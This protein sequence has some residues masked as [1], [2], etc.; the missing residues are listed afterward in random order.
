MP[1]LSLPSE[2]Q[3]QELETKLANET[4]DARYS[5]LYLKQLGIDID[6][7]G[8]LRIKNLETNEYELFVTEKDPLTGRSIV[9]GRGA[10][11]IVK[12][13]INLKTKERYILKMALFDNGD[14]A[15]NNN[16]EAH[17]RNEAKVNALFKRGDPRI[18]VKITLDKQPKAGKMY[19]IQ[20]YIPGETLSQILQSQSISGAEERFDIMQKVIAETQ[21][22]HDAGYLHRDLKVENILC[23]Q[24]TKIVKLIDLAAARCQKE[25]KSDGIQGTPGCIAPEIYQREEYSPASEMFAL[26]GILQDIFGIPEI[27]EGSH[28]GNFDQ[29]AKAELTH[30]QYEALCSLAKKMLMNDPAL[31]I[32]FPKMIKELQSI[33]SRPKVRSAVIAGDL[34]YIKQFSQTAI[35]ETLLEIEKGESALSLAVT[36]DKLDIVCYLI[37]ES[38]HGSATETRKALLKKCLL[39]KN[40]FG[41]N[42]LHQAV[43]GVEGKFSANAC[44]IVTLLA[45]TAD[46]LGISHY[47]LLCNEGASPLT[48]VQ[49]A[50]DSGNYPVLKTLVELG[51]ANQ[52]SPIEVAKTARTSAQ[53]LDCLNYLIAH[54]SL[55]K[56]YFTQQGITE[57]VPADQQNKLMEMQLLLAFEKTPEVALQA[58]KYFMTII[59]A[60]PL[61]AIAKMAWLSLK[62][63][64]CEL[65]AEAVAAQDTAEEKAEKT[66]LSAFENTLVNASQHLPEALNADKTSDFIKAELLVEIQHPETQT[67][68][69]QYYCQA[70]TDIPERVLAGLSKLNT[71]LLLTTPAQEFLLAKQVALAVILIEEEKFNKTAVTDFRLFYRQDGFRFRE[72]HYMLNGKSTLDEI[73]SAV[74]TCK[75]RPIAVGI[76]QKWAELSLMSQSAKPRP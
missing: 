72:F 29:R 39:Q 32:T 24:T 51:A 5:K 36:H 55:A 11:G 34:D 41:H 38:C 58:L 25:A 21:A 15:S 64:D 59:A 47:L 66:A 40:S 67:Q 26:G 28:F 37:D 35:F 50:V 12:M 4:I 6:R 49:L 2:S 48:A 75:H 8:I 54:T 19:H 22:L 73:I 52:L 70:I 43:V 31:R 18:L 17:L 61:S 13:L 62:H 68:A 7:G 14:I 45:K 30:A 23:D 46:L 74:S 63:V 16:T 10:F 27:R 56:I 3:I 53:A 9:L 33:S 65:A 20:K 76:P 71:K 69:F 60:D 57:A 44:E 42:V 1:H